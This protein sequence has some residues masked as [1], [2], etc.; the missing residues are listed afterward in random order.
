M[1]AAPPNVV[2]YDVPGGDFCAY[3]KGFWKR[4]LEWRHFGGSF[5]HL[6]STNNVVF[7]EE[8]LDA[9]RQ[10]NTQSVGS[11]VVRFC[12]GRSEG[13]TRSRIWPART[14]SRFVAQLAMAILT[15]KGGLSLTN[16]RDASIV[17]QFIPDE[18]GTFM[19]W[20][21]E[22]VTCHG[23]FKPE[24][25][26]AIFN[27]CLQE[28][29]VTIT[30]RILDANST[31]LTCCAQLAVALDAGCTWLRYGSLAEFTEWSEELLAAARPADLVVLLVRLS[32]L[33]A[34]HPELQA[35]ECNTSSGDGCE[36][37]VDIA[38]GSAMEQFVRDLGRYDAEATTAPLVVML[39]PSPPAAMDRS[40]ALEDE[41]RRKIEVLPNVH[42]QTSNQIMALFQQQYATAFYDAVADKRQHS[43]YTQAMLNVLS[44]SICR[45][46]CR[47]FRTASSRKK[48]IVLDCDNTLW[49]G[50]VAEV[51]AAG[52]AIEPRFLALQRF[53]VA[54]QQ[55]G[56]LLA[57][58]SKNILEDVTRAFEQRR[59]D[60]VLDLHEHVVAT[61]VNWRPKSEN[62][63]QLAEELSLGAF[64]SVVRCSEVAAALPSVTVIRL[65]DAF[66]ESFLDQE[67][68]FDESFHLQLRAAAV[69][70][71]EDSSRTQL[72]RQNRERQ[73]LRAATSTHTAFLSALGVR[74]VFE[75]LDS[76]NERLARSPSFTRIL[77]LHHRTNQ[78][79]TSTTFAKR[80]DERALLDY[81][82]AADHTAI[83]A[84]VTDRFGHYGL[85]SAA[86]CHIMPGGNVLR[87]D[88]LL[89]SCRALNRG[90]EHAMVRK[91]SEVAARTGSTMMEFVWEPTER[92]QPAHLFF[93]V[94]SDVEFVV[95][96]GG[97]EQE[98]VGEE[99]QRQSCTA[100]GMWLVA[101]DKASQVSFL[102]AGDNVQHNDVS[103]HSTLAWFLQF[104]PIRWLR[105]AALSSLQ[106]TLTSFAP[107]WMLNWMSTWSEFK[108]LTSRDGG[109]G[110]S[111]SL[112]VSFCGRGSLD[113]FI[114]PALVGLPRTST[115]NEGGTIDP[116][117]LDKFRRKARHQTKLALA[118]HLHEETPRVVWSANR[119][120]AE[121][122]RQ[123]GVN[124]GDKGESVSGTQIHAASLQ[125]SCQSSR[126]S[127]I[128]QRDSRCS[129]HMCRNCCYRVQ[130]L[131]TRSQHHANAEARRSAVDVLQAEFAKDA[132]QEAI[133]HALVSGIDAKL[134]EAH[135]NK[136][137][138]GELCPTE[139]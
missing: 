54:Q 46:I 98:A 40:K 73:Q 11:C 79:S 12:G 70:T 56:I 138:R 86:L 28:S 5:K 43:P 37:T 96:S 112:R 130:R 16:D 62:I 134:C 106:W 88:S 139:A 41:M 42:M 26:V 75:E 60:M 120:Y 103:T 77:Q 15:Q 14:P 22:G 122:K 3:L 119:S 64:A 115:L 132:A 57:L 127:A 25:S 107:Q 34:A 72:Y 94:L 131:L 2:R 18:Q 24:S 52:I 123:L 17:T 117:E 45:Q 95:E 4:N 113:E 69:S 53:V 13:H 99:K 9:A 121:E 27:F 8:D 58:C 19:E 109:G 20:S 110:A 65:P 7:I 50:A 68:V 31:W 84:H 6:R 100:A 91:L 124:S 118:D 93:S 23:V 49:G 30:Y 97:L 129:F 44:L 1:S 21:F 63:A 125:L 48:V 61:K 135:Q 87:V 136:R 105:D 104:F 74:I 29:M 35:V 76:E 85:V 67:W 83:C 10:P 116:E 71:A 59:D 81:V 89:L 128:V 51:G 36:K 111:G 90:V 33:D 108:S 38:D 66:S 92:N 126:C 32:D 137:R 114:R 102:K 80:L 101:T 78:F 82:T 47:L 55:C 133:K 39:C